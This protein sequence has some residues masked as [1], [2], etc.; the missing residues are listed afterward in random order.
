MWLADVAGRGGRSIRGDP[1]GCGLGSWPSDDFRFLLREAKTVPG[2]SVI[3]LQWGDEAKGKLVDL[4]AERL[5]VEIVVR[6]PGGSQCR[7]HGRD[8]RRNL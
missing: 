5:A 6:V 1:F 3:G 8:W 7:P 2:T 4:L